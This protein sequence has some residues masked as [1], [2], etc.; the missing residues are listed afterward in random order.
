MFETAPAEGPVPDCSIVVPVYNEPHR[1][2]ISLVA[3]RVNDLRG[4]YNLPQ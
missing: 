1:R 3:M 2:A 4:R